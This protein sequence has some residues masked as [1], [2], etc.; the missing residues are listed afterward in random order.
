MNTSNPTGPAVTPTDNTKLISLLTLAAGAVALPQTG[1]ADIIYTDMTSSPTQVGWAT[2]DQFLFTL[3]GNALFGFQRQETSTSTAYGA[4]TIYYRTVLAGDLGGGSPAGIRANSSNGLAVAMPF[5]ATWSQGG[6]A[7]FYNAAVGV[8]N[9]L[10]G[11]LPAAG[12]DHQYLAW[13]FSDS[14]QSGDMRYGWVEISLALYSYAGG[15]PEVT[16]WGYAYD[17]TGAK[18]TMGAVPEPTSGALLVMGAMALGARGLRKWRQQREAASQ[19][20]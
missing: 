3:P 16:I 4:S 12:Y 8:V 13:V 17:N 11:R 2:T 6:D 14:T 9:D 1:Q 10:G 20:A 7:I 18:P 15:G 19:T 5:G